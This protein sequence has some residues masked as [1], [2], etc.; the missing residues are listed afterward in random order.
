MNGE[1]QAMNV[2]NLMGVDYPQIRDFHNSA[3]LIDL[4][5]SVKKVYS[6][7]V[8]VKVSEFEMKF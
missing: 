4:I 7:K 1:W 3:Y 2:V 5:H 6:Q 8:N